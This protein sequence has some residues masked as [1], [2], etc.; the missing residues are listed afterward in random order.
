MPRP[1][2]RSSPFGTAPDG[3]PVERWHL[4]S[5]SGVRAEVLTYGGVLHAL[6]VPDRWGGTRSVVLSLPGVD[7]YAGPSPYLGAL[8]GRYANRIAEGRFTLDGREHRVPVNDRGHALHGGPEGFDRRVWTAAPVPDDGA[9]AVRLT[10]RSPDGDMGFPGALEVSVTYRLDARGTLALDYRATADRPTV[11]NLTSHAYF[12]LSGGPTVAD[13]VLLLDAD[14]YLPVTGAGIPYGPL[15]ATAGTPFD[16]TTPHAIGERLHA[17]D[18]QL[19]AAGG[20]DHCWVLRPPEGGAGP[21]RA[22]RLE[23]PVS[24]RAMEVWTTEPG[25]QVYTG[26]LL[27]GSLRD[28]AGRRHERYGAV[29]LETQHLPDSPNRPEYPSTVLRPGGVLRSRTEYRFSLSASG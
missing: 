26:N 9:A 14:R 8:V 13:Q 4:D 22:A 16:F 29:C 2:L 24:G 7:D 5:G 11:V 23:D 28:A 3:T 20:Y 21:R 1:V 15:A 27:D 10:L 18:P 25:L 12:N 17:P 6:E 19:R